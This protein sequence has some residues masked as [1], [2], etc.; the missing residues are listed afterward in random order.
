ML[1]KFQEISGKFS[2]CVYFNLQRIN[3]KLKLPPIKLLTLMYVFS[4]RN[5]H[6]R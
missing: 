5:K 4:Q 3:I 2:E 1:Y 6:F